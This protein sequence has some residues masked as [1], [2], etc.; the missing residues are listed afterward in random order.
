MP[1]MERG[2]ASAPPRGHLPST[3][4]EQDHASRIRL[5]PPVARQD[6]SPPRP[7][8]GVTPFSFNQRNGGAD[9][10]KDGGFRGRDN[11]ASTVSS[12]TRWRRCGDRVSEAGEQHFP[13]ILAVSRYRSSRVEEI[14]GAVFSA[15]PAPEIVPERCEAST[16]PGVLLEGMKTPGWRTSTARAREYRPRVL[17]HRAAHRGRQFLGKPRR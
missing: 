7:D 10:A 15:R 8:N 12:T 9:G 3:G 4:V 1:C 11:R 6:G 17:P 5:P 16:F 13:G 2:T 14:R